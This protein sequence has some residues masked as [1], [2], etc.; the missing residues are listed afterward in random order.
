[1]AHHLRLIELKRSVS[2]DLVTVGDNFRQDER[3]AA[4][5]RDVG[6]HMYR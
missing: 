5:A 6:W 3:W 1:M 2:E 4:R